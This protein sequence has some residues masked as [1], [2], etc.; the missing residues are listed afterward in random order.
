MSMGMPIDISMA[1]GAIG[2][3][4]SHS[5]RL[6][7]KLGPNIGMKPIGINARNSKPGSTI[8]T[9]SFPRFRPHPIKSGDLPQSIS[10]YTAGVAIITKGHQL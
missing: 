3:Y 5:M 4:P 10:D 7:L 6:T 8:A 9:H 2:A 1:D